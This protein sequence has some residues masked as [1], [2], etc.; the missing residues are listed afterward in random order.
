MLMLFLWRFWSLFWMEFA[1][2]GTPIRRGLG[3]TSVIK[4]SPTGDYFFSG[5]LYVPNRSPKFYV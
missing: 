1:G 4:W 3:G 5:I 2:T